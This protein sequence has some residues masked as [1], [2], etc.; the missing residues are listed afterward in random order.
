MSEWRAP[1]RGRRGCLGQWR[2]RSRAA[3][4]AWASKS[5]R[6]FGATG[7]WPPR[8]LSGS[9]A[10]GGRGEPAAE[11]S[12]LLPP[13]SPSSPPFLLFSF[14]FLLSC[15]SQRQR[16]EA[17]GSARAAAPC[18]PLLAS[19]RGEGA[20]SLF[21][22]FSP[23]FAAEQKQKGAR[24]VASLVARG[25]AGRGRPSGG[26]GLRAGEEQRAL[27]T[28]FC[29]HSLHFQFSFIFARSLLSSLAGPLASASLASCRKARGLLAR[30]PSAPPR[31]A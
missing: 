23:L 31:L 29:Q 25:V 22:P 18:S 4:G 13:F 16:R 7:P 27:L 28:L 10:A 11:A 20:L 2:G 9:R 24:E 26:G 30:R 15:R 8:R 3:G 6:G 19:P 12:S 17:A 5:L 14:L 21:A 1:R